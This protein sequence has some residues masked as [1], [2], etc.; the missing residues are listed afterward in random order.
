[1]SEEKYQNEY[2]IQSARADWHD[3][4][5][6]MY[7]ITICTK[8][9]KHYFGEIKKCG[10]EDEPAITLT[11]IGEY[12]DQQL[13]EVSI[14]YPYAEIPLWTIMPNHIHAVILILDDKIPQNNL[15]VGQRNSIKQKIINNNVETGRAPSLQSTTLKHSAQSSHST[16]HTH[17][18]QSLQGLNQQKGWLSVV[19]GGI[20]SAIT[21]FAHAQDIPFEWQTRFHDHIIRGTDEL[22]KISDYIKK[23]VARWEYDRFY[24]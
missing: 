9:R 4:N 12:T 24:K 16:T 3:Y 1:M 17:S 7:F 10:K 18:A 19:V 8:D 5:G 14:H 23:N 15:N 21:K 22:N 20:K 11:K 13:Q 2:R 6:G